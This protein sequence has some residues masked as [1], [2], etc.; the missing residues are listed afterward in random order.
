MKQKRWIAVLA[1][2]IVLASAGIVLAA[3]SC[4]GSLAADSDKGRVNAY[5]L[6]GGATE[7]KELSDLFAI[8]EDN[9]ADDIDTFFAVR[10]IANVFARRKQ[11]HKLINFLTARVEQSPEDQYNSYYLLAVADAYMKQDAYPVAAMYLDMVVKNYPDLIIRGN[12]I[13]LECLKQL[14]GI[15]EDPAQKIWYYEELISR[16]KETIDA[17]PTYFLLGKT[18]ENVGEWNKA[19]ESYTQ[20][21]QYYVTAVPGYPDAYSYAKQLVDFSNSQKNWAFESL[22]SMITAIKAALDAGDMRQLWQYRAKVNFFARSWAHGN[23][24]GGMARFTLSSFTTSNRIRYAENLE[25]GSNA[26]EAYLKTSGWSLQLTTV[27]YFYFRKIHFPPDPEI[28]GK[29]EWAG[30]YYG[31]KF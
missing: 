19:I 5:Y 31:E 13:H 21:L 14:I 24:D 17:G 1:T 28:H 10:E 27:W 23:D 15:T 11:Y 7:K 6:S 18:Y 20:F 8:L 29:W 25:A 4:N 12:P 26:N 30:I 16:F 22:Q 9:A 3:V 2:V